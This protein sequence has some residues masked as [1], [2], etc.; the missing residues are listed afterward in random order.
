MCERGDVCFGHFSPAGFGPAGSVGLSVGTVPR[1]RGTTN[2]MSRGT[3]GVFIGLAW[4]QGSS[5][6]QA[7]LTWA[8]GSV[9]VSGKVRVQCPLPFI[10]KNGWWR[11]GT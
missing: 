6:K 2:C 10:K 9:T 11:C 3:L 1:G 4:E 7:P 8:R 5:W